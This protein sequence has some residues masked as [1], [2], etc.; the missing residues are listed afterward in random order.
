MKCIKLVEG[1]SH[2]RQKEMSHIYLTEETRKSVD[3]TLDD[4][5]NHCNGII[6]GNKSLGEKVKYMNGHTPNSADMSRLDNGASGS[7]ICSK[8]KSHGRK[9]PAKE[10]PPVRTTT[11]KGKPTRRDGKPLTGAAL[12]SKY[13]QEAW[14][15]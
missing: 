2:P 11:K 8:R 9:R 6:R 14:K 13:G 1:L 15:S 5:I 3:V 4:L 12:R 10:E 7:G